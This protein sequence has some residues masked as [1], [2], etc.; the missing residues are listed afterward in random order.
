AGI[1]NS[2]RVI[3]STVIKVYQCPSDDANAKPFS[4]PTLVPEDNWARGN[5]AANA[6]FEDYD[7]V[8]GGEKRMWTRQGPAA[9]GGASSPDLPANYG[10]KL[11]VIT[12]QDGTSNT[13]M[14][15][16]IRAGINHLDPRGV[17]AMGFPGASITNA[18]R[19]QYNPT[20]NNLLG[21]SG[22]DGD[23]IQN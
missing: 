17:W 15:N 12:V 18:G 6:G 21:D 5:Y 19:Q 10:A 7:H 1:N 13:I 9:V 4:D 23:E 22:S 2:W 16:E 8:N 14:I 11:G 20:P 3:R